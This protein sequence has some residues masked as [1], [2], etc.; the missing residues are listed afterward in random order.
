M[1]GLGWAPVLVA[2][3][4]CLLVGCE[5]L[6]PIPSGAVQVH[7][8]DTD[9]ELHAQPATVPA[10]DIYLVLDGPRQ[11]VSFVARK[12][13]AEETPGPMS[14][15]DLDRLARGDTEGT[16]MEGFS[17]GCD[18][19]QRAASRGQMGHCGNV[20]KLRLAAGKYALLLDPPEGVIVPPA[21][22]VILE[23]TP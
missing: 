11:S 10:G 13:T 16:S 12:R 20:Y 19:G 14:D 18:A 6:T 23:V 5:G 8:T 1:K 2:L 9:S 21:T 7:I 17:V 22:M 15:D 4:A 3:V